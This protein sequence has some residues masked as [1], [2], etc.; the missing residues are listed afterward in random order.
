MLA[1]QKTDECG[2]D[3]H[4]GT[5]RPGEDVDDIRTRQ[6]RNGNDFLTCRPYRLGADRTAEETWRWLSQSLLDDKDVGLR[7]ER[8][9]QRRTK[10]VA[11]REAIRRGPEGVSSALEA[12]RVVDKGLC[13]PPPIQ[14]NGFFANTRTPL[15]DAVELFDLHL[16]LGPASVDEQ[17]SEEPS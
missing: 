15:L 12:W 17:N 4:V 9:S 10:V 13:L 16:S 1:E 14:N 6:Y 11:L 3:W 7:G 5:T 2:L 8:W